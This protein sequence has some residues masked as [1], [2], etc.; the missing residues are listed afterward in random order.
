MVQVMESMGFKWQIKAAVLFWLALTASSTWA[1]SVVFAGVSFTGDYDQQAARY[2]YAAEL[3]TRRLPSGQS[4]L[5]AELRSTIDSA[6][7]GSL[8]LLDSGINSAS[9][10]N[11]ALSFGIT[12]EGIEEVTWGQGYLYIYRVMASVLVFDFERSVLVASYPAIVQFQDGS[13]QKRTSKDHLAIFETIYSASQPERSIMHEWV[14]RLNKLEIKQSLPRYL[15]VRSVQLAEGVSEQLPPRQTPDAYAT[16]VAQVFEALLSKQQNVAMVPYTAGQAVGQAMPLSFQDATMF[17][18]TLPEPNF[19]FDL[20]ISPFKHAEKKKGRSA[21]HA[22]GAFFNMDFSLAAT[23]KSYLNTRFKQVN[24]SVFNEK[25]K[26]NVDVWQSQQTALRGLMNS[27]AQ[28]IS[29]R[30]SA[31][32]AKMTKDN[33]LEQLKITEEKIALCR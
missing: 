16:A 6:Y 32:L 27:V 15:G 9:G 26:V 21:Q 19:V 5:D 8:D 4:L 20:T 12:A 33:I 28:Q 13:R 7:D 17:Q 29:T 22:F 25:D 2:P 24:Q 30:D 1:T 23:G 11:L 3:A 18:L 14:S 31:A 10:D